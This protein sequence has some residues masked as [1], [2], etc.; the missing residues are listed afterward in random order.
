VPPLIL[1]VD[2]DRQP[3]DTVELYLRHTGFDVLQGDLPRLRDASGKPLATMVLAGGGGPATPRG[4]GRRGA[5]HPAGC[6]HDA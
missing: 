2:D 3:V 6:R 5:G 1:V 4:N